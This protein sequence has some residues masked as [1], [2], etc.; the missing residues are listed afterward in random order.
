MTRTNY[1]IYTGN[2]SILYAR[3]LFILYTQQLLLLI[4]GIIILILLLHFTY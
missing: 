2:N 4:S 3:V 1:Q